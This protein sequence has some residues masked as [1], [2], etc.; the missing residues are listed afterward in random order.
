MDITPQL[1]R[2]EVMHK[3]L[4]PKVNRFRY[5]V[6]YVCLPLPVSGN[7]YG[8]QSKGLISFLPNDHGP[9]DG[10]N[11]YEWAQDIL[12]ENGM[13]SMQHIMLLAMPRIL[14]Y[15][16]NPISMWF[17]LDS[18]YQP[19]AVICEVNNTFGESHSYLCAGLNGEV[20]TQDD[21]MVAEKQ[22]HVSPF[23]PR[24]GRYSFRF[25]IKKEKLAVW[26]DYYDAENH[27]QLMTTL[28]GELEPLTRSSLRLAFWTHPLV[29]LKT[30]SLIHWQA[31]KLFAKGIRYIVKPQQKQERISVAHHV[32]KM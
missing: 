28:R 1:F 11:L 9:R 24:G 5:S 29:T 7:D 3:R 30:I 20:L 22:F 27:L 31:L 4:F 25:A 19:R 17:C 6:Y 26:I 14:G 13:E 15:A 10:S 18:Q 32:T 12:K 21:V 23:L 2:A 16:F 8:L